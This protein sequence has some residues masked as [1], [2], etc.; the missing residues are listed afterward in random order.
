MGSGAA[1]LRPGVD[2]GLERGR[3][4]RDPVDVPPHRRT[5][6]PGMPRTARAGAGCL[7][8]ASR[9]GEGTHGQKEEI[10]DRGPRPGAGRGKTEGMDQ[11][12]RSLR[13]CRDRSFLGTL[14]SMAGRDRSW[15]HRCPQAGR[16]DRATLWGRERRS[17]EHVEA[18]GTR[19]STLREKP[20]F[21]EGYPFLDTIPLPSARERNRISGRV[22]FTPQAEFSTQGDRRCLAALARRN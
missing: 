6:E 3:V 22:G 13:A 9:A 16:C 12:T 21:P 11:G 2:R 10:P 5:G 14:P 17:P 8:D 15:E 18:W 19:C 1:A 20:P 4:S 7:P